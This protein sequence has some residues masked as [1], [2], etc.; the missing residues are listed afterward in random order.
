MNRLVLV[1][2]SAVLAFGSAAGLAAAVDA[3][4]SPVKIETSG[5]KKAPVI[6]EHAKHSD[7]PCD[8]CHHAH[9]N[10]GDERVCIKCHKLTDDAVTKAP[11][12]ETAMHGKDKGACY[13]CHR[14]EDAEH[15]LKCA[16][17]HKG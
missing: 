2:L 8:R 4:T 3:P 10:A 1:T 7:K 14:A 15:K 11:K 5:G 16:D 6:F 9:D 13:A 12:I 17:C